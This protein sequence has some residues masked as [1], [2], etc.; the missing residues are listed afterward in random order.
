MFVNFSDQVPQCLMMEDDG[1]ES[2]DL[3]IDICAITPPA[4]PAPPEQS[5]S[6]GLP[7]MAE[8]LSSLSAGLYVTDS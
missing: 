6:D 2:S 3:D 1:E 7:R 5:A 8:L 4:S